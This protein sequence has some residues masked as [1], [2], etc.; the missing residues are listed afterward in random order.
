MPTSTSRS[1]TDFVLHRCF[2]LFLS[3][4]ATDTVSPRYCG[5]QNKAVVLLVLLF[6]TAGSI[7]GV[8][9]GFQMDGRTRRLGAA[10]ALQARPRH[11]AEY[12]IN[13]GERSP[14]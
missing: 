10:K 11:P 7:C 3:V 4:F 13:K 8:A 1:T 2:H 14:E 6:M 12:A 5:F 9:E